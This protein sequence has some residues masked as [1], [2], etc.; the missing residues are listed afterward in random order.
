MYIYIMG[1]MGSNLHTTSDLLHVIKFMN[2]DKF[3]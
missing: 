3:L 2:Y 1:Y